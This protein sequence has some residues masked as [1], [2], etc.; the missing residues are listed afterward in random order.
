MTAT[1]R[2]PKHLAR[3]RRRFRLASMESLGFIDSPGTATTWTTN[4]SLPPTAPVAQSTAGPIP[5]ED[6]FKDWTP[7]EVG[8]RLLTGNI[9]W[10]FMAG[11]LMIA[12]GLVGIGYWVYQQ[13]EAAADAAMAELQEQVALLRPVLGAL[14]ESDLSN[15]GS[16]LSA[17]L[18]EIDTV[19]RT[20]FDTSGTLPGSL[21]EQ[22]A[23]AA[24]IAGD[25]L[26][27]S[28]LINDAH[29]YRSAV[30][31][32]LAVPTFQADP[33]LIRLDEAAR[34]VG[35]WQT[36]FNSVAS[37]LPEGTMTELGSELTLISGELD[38]IQTRYLDALRSDDRFGAHSALDDLSKRLRTAEGMLASSMERVL[39]RARERLTNALAGVELLVG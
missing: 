13:P 31:P 18:M 6:P 28:R 23:I 26:E 21:S 17:S 20:V 37:A 14:I 35:E 7:S 39:G 2:K 10:G 12:T 5:H 16:D 34:E 30:I 19:A 1:S 33:N 36:H 25:A 29:A 3:R 4:A 27:G 38:A 32:I 24:D 22:R 15:T 9:R 11:M 8:R